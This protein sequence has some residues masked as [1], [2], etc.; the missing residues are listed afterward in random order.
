MNIEVCAAPI[1]VIGSPRSG[2]TA[3]A[4]AL[5]DHR[6]LWT[7]HESY[8][9]HHLYGKDRAAEA[10][11]RDADRQ[12]APSWIKTEGVSKQEFLAFL[13]VGINALYTSRSGGRRWIEQ[14]PLN[15]LM[16]DDLAAMF[17]GAQF[18]HIVRD[19][20]QVV[21]SMNNFLAKFERRPAA[22]QYVPSWAADFAEACRTWRRW[23][24]TGAAFCAR[25]PDRA[26]TV[27]N[28]RLSA[29]PTDGFGEL[30]RFLGL[31]WEDGPVDAFSGGRVNS[32][33]VG[34]AIARPSRQAPPTWD[35]ERRAVF[36]EEAGELMLSLGLASWEDLQDWLVSDGAP[37]TLP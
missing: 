6:A 28:E 33:F 18:V 12:Q 35:A 30:Y 26:V 11:R 4:R 24:E 1:F 32:S 21:H 10:W 19:G 22:R 34:A 29:D 37:V 36:V 5:S 20:R 15:T 9:L 8:V 7:S 13:G 17:P 31:D 23:T 25:H 14:T 16:A 2:T 27:V 3:L